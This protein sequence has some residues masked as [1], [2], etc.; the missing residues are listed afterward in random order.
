MGYV[1]VLK[2]ED[3]D[4]LKIEVARTLSRVLQHCKNYGIDLENSYR[5][6]PHIHLKSSKLESVLLDHTM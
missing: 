3:K 5:I 6:F 1:Y 2:L 4:L